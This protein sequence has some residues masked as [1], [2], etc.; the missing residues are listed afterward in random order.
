MKKSFAVGVLAAVAMMAGPAQAEWVPKKPIKIVVG[1]SPGGGTDIIARNIASATQPFIPVPLVIVNRAGAAGTLAGEYVA[2]GQPDGYTLLVA[3]GSESVSVGNHRKLNFDIRKD[4]SPIIRFNLLRIFIATN[5]K[6]GIKSLK[7]LVAK[8]KANPGKL[9]FA[10]AGT[11]SAYHS[12][13]LV[14]ASRAGMDLKHVPYKGGAPALAALLGGH[15]DMTFSVGPELAPHQASGRINILGVAS[16]DRHPAFPKIP[17]FKEQGFDIKVEMMKGLVGP[18]G[19]S[20]EAVEYLHAK[21]KQGLE[22][23]VWKRL[24]KKSKLETAYLE[25]PAF[26]KA[27]TSTFESIGAVLKNK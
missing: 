13:G 25:G 27:M 3:G 2:K 6:S 19:M 7:D 5:A 12:T 21:F 10:S 18:A 24:A 11:G 15:V 16:D 20:R 26:Q 8:A 4:F 17:T 22:T 23:D 9:T 1:F 14:F